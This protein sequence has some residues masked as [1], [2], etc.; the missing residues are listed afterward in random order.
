MTHASHTVRDA[1]LF[2]L[3]LLRQSGHTAL[4]AG[5]CVRDMLLDRPPKDYDVATDATPERVAEVFP[6]ANHVGAKF[7]VMLVRKYGHDVEV[8]T[9]RSDGDYSDGRH[10]DEIRFGTDREDAARRDFTINGMFFDPESG[11]VIDYVGGREDLASGTLR[12][13]G[14]PHRRFTEDH[15]RMLR[16]VRFAARLGFEVDAS[17]AEAIRALA[18]HLASISPER[19][20]MELS[21]ILADPTRSRAWELLVT[22][23]LGNHLAAGWSIDSDRYAE[24]PARLA[25]LGQNV[26]DPALGMAAVICRESAKSAA[27]VGRA[28]RQ[29]NR[30]IDTVTW[31]V[32]ALPG[33]RHSDTLELAD[34]KE[35][36]AAPHWLHLVALLRAD[37]A[38][39]GQSARPLETL[40]ARADGI[41]QGRIAPPPLLDGDGLA[42]LGVAP[43]PRFGE[44]LRHVYRA[45]LNEQIDSEK[46]AVA[47]AKRLMDQG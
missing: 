2:V 25:A 28:L 18:P 24:V 11:T 34:I 4:F 30:Q 9:F 46:E 32:D 42:R 47:W 40:L 5:G 23:G 6:W 17:T 39:R 19:V 26:I 7:G 27:A 33:A 20:W 41:P 15:L 22:L 1:A 14:D 43:G 44:I 3:R 8:A 38:A 13:I 21:Q 16:A 45:Q 31:L 10:P 35:L 29:S 36:M 12:T 37:L